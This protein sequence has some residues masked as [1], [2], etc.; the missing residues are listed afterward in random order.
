VCRD[1]SDGLLRTRIL[2][3]KPTAAT[4]H[5]IRR[6][7][8]ARAAARR[9]FE[10]R[11]A[12]QILNKPSEKRCDFASHL[13]PLNHQA[14]RQCRSGPLGWFKLSFAGDVSALAFY[15]L[16]AASPLPAH[17][18]L[19]C[20]ADRTSSGCR[21]L[22]TPAVRHIDW[23]RQGSPT[24]RKVGPS[25]EARS[26]CLDFCILCEG[27]RVFHVN[28]KIAHRVLDLAMT[29][30]DLDGTKVAGCLVDDRCLRSSK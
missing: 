4:C 3:W 5:C 23:E 20:N 24:R 30:K 17:F 22:T 27:K 6:A 7:R 2:T 12:A 18:L 15:C 19:V 26:P 14:Q 21:L 28:P 8:S 10:N 29:E 13:E 11:D 25:P 9:H 1:P 16:K